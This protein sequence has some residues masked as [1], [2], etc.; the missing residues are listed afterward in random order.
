MVKEAPIR[1]DNERGEA[2]EDAAGVTRPA[3]LTLRLHGRQSNLAF[4]ATEFGVFCSI[5]G[6]DNG[7]SF[8]D[9][10]GI[11]LETEGIH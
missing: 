2:D 4:C 9:T 5:G 6:L 3:T 10:R 11:V 1:G 7:G 8:K